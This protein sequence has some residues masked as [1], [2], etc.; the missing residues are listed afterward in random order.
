MT[1]PQQPALVSTVG[2]DD[3][4]FSEYNVEIHERIREDTFSYYILGEGTRASESQ[5]PALP[6][7]QGNDEVGV[8]LQ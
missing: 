2:T 8:G 5:N 7:P 3:P 1:S 4:S 6:I